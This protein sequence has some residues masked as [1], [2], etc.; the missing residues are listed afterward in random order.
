MVELGVLDL[1]VDVAFVVVDGVV[2][3]LGLL[4]D[5]AQTLF[6]GLHVVSFV[7][8]AAEV[9]VQT[10]HFLTVFAVEHRLF[11]VQGTETGVFGE[12]LQFLHQVV[13]S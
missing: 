8:F 5:R 4:L 10:H 11:G 12:H 1:G 2:D 3:V 6:H 9:A 7:F 13:L